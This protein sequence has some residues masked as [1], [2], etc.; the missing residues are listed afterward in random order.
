MEIPRPL[1]DSSGD[2]TIQMV[3]FA[4]VLSQSCDVAS[5][6]TRFIYARLEQPEGCTACSQLAFREFEYFGK[7]FHFERA[8]GL[9]TAMPRYASMN[10]QAS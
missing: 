10:R 3:T 4:P 8:R 1:R 7:P 2:L 5:G 6:C 9:A